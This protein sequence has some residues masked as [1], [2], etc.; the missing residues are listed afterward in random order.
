MKKSLTVFS[1]AFIPARKIIWPAPSD[2]ERLNLIW[3]RGCR[4]SLVKQVKKKKDKQQKPKRSIIWRRMRLISCGT[5]PVKAF[6]SLSLR[7]RDLIHF[8]SLLP[9]Y[10]SLVLLTHFFIMYF[11][12]EVRNLQNQVKNKFFRCMHGWGTYV[13]KDS[14]IIVKSIPLMEKLS[15]T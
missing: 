6:K 13:M 2:T 11:L 10:L 15:A 1:V 12:I 5:F 4:I 3:E 14:T 9:N 8:Y 7:G